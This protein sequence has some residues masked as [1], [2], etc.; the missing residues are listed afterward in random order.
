MM[1]DRPLRAYEGPLR[2][3]ACGFCSK[4]QM[5]AAHLIAGR[6]DACICD[7]CVLICLEIVA[8]ARGHGR[9]ARLHDKLRQTLEDDG[10]NAAAKITR[11]VALLEAW[12][13]EEPDYFDD[14]NFG[15]WEKG[16]IR[17]QRAARRELRD[18]LAPPP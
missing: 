5:E 9:S 10:F 14:L 11:V 16:Y 4:D 1:D 18:E 7:A 6:D 13:R 12:S 8:E 15:P 2:D 3:Y 17:G